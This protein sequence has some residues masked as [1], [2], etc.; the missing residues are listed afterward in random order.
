[1]SAWDQY[2]Q[3]YDSLLEAADNT[4]PGDRAGIQDAQNLRSEMSEFAESVD[5]R[6]ALN[7]PGDVDI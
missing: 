7:P 2:R 5:G 6:V 3:M 1:M 4:Q